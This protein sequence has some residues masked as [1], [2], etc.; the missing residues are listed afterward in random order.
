MPN[1]PVPVPQ[2]NF[3]LNHIELRRTCVAVQGALLDVA[4]AKRVPSPAKAS[5]NTTVR[6]DWSARQKELDLAVRKST[7]LSKSPQLAS[8]VA[9]V[10]MVLCTPTAMKAVIERDP[11]CQFV[12]RLEAM[13]AVK[14]RQQREE[15]A[16]LTYQQFGPQ[17]E[18]PCVF[19]EST[20]EMK[21]RFD[22]AT[23]EKYA[24]HYKQ[25]IAKSGS[26]EG[27]PLK[28]ASASLQMSPPAA[29]EKAKEREKA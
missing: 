14:D 13:S 4:Q 15:I 8:K 27:E 20:D 21:K 24:D 9:G 1:I 22:N 2:T 17:S 7:S 18:T 11:R 12:S 28:L 25:E 19:L 26:V 10:D 16:D 5:P 29:M 3:A 23:V 6:L